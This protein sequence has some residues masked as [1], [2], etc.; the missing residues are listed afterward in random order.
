MLQI[1]FSFALSVANDI[2]YL[3]NHGENFASGFPFT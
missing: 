3:P 1:Q 2:Y